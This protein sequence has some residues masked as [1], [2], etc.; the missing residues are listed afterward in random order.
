[1]NLRLRKLGNLILASGGNGGWKP[2][3]LGSSRKMGNLIWVAGGAFCLYLTVGSAFGQSN[4]WDGTVAPTGRSTT[5]LY[6]YAS[7]DAA[8]GNN[9]ELR[10]RSAPNQAQAPAGRS[11]SEVMLVVDDEPIPTPARR[12]PAEAAQM[13]SATDEDAN[14]ASSGPRN[15][16]CCTSGWTCSWFN[17]EEFRWPWAGC[18]SGASAYFRDFYTFAGAQSFN[19]PFNINFGD[20]GFHEGFNW[21]A[22]LWQAAGLGIQFGGSAN[23]SDLLADNGGHLT[24]YFITAGLFHRATGDGGLQGG[25]V[26]DM[27]ANDFAFVDFTVGQLRG[28]LSYVLYGNE[29]GCWFTSSV[30]S[31]IDTSD[32]TENTPVDVYAFYY[33]HHFC[34]GGEEHFWGGYANHLGGLIGA[35]FSVPLNDQFVL[36][37]DIDYM[38]PNDTSSHS[39][40]PAALWNIGVNL[41]W[42][43]GCH[44]RDTY[45][46]EYR[47]LFNVADNGTFFWHPSVIQ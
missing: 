13:P 33:A 39:T 36:A 19:D 27:L 35:D 16:N 24:Q 5:A 3:L 41:E 28:N 22:P 46:S 43:P 34:G 44:A 37:A 9:S 40:F 17:G 25:L 12:L 31:A 6:S 20:F 11:N 38:I 1:M 18:G 32:S 15:S 7:D 10:L 42:H 23:H 30:K 47:P 21:G 45:E 4:G 26:Y 8:A 2:P 29:I 14:S